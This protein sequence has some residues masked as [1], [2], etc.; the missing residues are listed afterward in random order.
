M[1][2]KLKGEMELQ[3]RWKAEIQTQQ[4]GAHWRMMKH[5]EKRQKT[6]EGYEKEEQ[7]CMQAEKKRHWR[8]WKEIEAKR[9]NRKKGDA[10]HCVAKSI[11]IVQKF[12]VAENVESFEQCRCR[13]RVN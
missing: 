11:K 6:G 2:R 4:E 12:V 3:K 8:K 10:F 5:S 9:Q 7:Q 13:K 1:L